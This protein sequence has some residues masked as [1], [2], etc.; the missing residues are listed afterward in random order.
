MELKSEPAYATINVTDLDIAFP[1][2]L[3]TFTLRDGLDTYETDGTARCLTL[4]FAAGGILTFHLQH[5]HWVAKRSRTIRVVVP[6]DQAAKS[7]DPQS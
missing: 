7:A 4:K 1:G 2:D 6:A 3:Q 5:A